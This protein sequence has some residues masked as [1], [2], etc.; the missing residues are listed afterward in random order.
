[1]KKLFIIFISTVL[2][3]LTLLACNKKSENVIRV[4]EVTDSFFYAPFYVAIEKGFFEEEGLKIELTNGGGSEVSMTALL[5]GGADIILAGPETVVY[6]ANQQKKDS[7]KVFAQLTKR[8]GCFLIGRTPE[9]NFSW[10]N[11]KGK[12]VITGRKGGLPAMTFDYI[13]KQKGFTSEDITLRTDV[14]FPA[15]AS[16]F[17]SGVGDYVTL[18]EPTATEFCDAKKGYIVASVGVESGEVPYTSFIALSSYME[19]NSDKIEK[20]TKALKKAVD[21]VMN[22]SDLEVSK[23]LIKHFT[24]SNLE[25]TAKSLKNYKDVDTWSSDLILTEDMFS[26]LLKIIKNSGEETGTVSYN[27]VVETKFAKKL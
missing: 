8:D 9:E 25:S 1:M 13:V 2:L 23:Y 24:G 14:Q 21:F 10:E 18:F 22:E 26:T 12:T 17:D 5:S 27:I 16:T 19:K 6:I 15:M 20:F 4:N 11:L 7:P 3:L